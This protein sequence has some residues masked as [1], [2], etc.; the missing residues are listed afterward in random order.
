[1]IERTAAEGASAL[2]E[3]IEAALERLSSQELAEHPGAYGAMDA[4]IRAAL[5]AG[6][7]A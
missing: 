1:L 3:R 7:P 2:T 4:D 5:G 6:E